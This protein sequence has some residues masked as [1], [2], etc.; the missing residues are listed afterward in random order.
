MTGALVRYKRMKKRAGLSSQSCAGGV[1]YGFLAEIA[2][3]GAEIAET[4]TCYGEALA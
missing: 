2:E 3:T 1:Q 4:K